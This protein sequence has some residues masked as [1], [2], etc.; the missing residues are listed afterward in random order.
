MPTD[1]DNP[2][3]AAADLPNFA[4]I[5]AEHVA[6]AVAQAVATARSQLA[7]IEGLSLEQ[8]PD[9]LQGLEKIADAVGRVW[10]P[11]EHLLSVRDDA[12]MRQA[13]EVAQP[14]IVEV[15]IDIAQNQLIYQTLVALVAS[16]LWANVP[17]FARRA[18][19]LTVREAQ[20]AGVGLQ[21]QAA[22][23]FGE[24]QQQLAELS[25]QFAH[26]VLDS[27]K[28]WHLDLSE[29]TD[30][31]GLP[32]TWLR[33][34]AQSW[35]QA[36]SQPPEQAPDFTQGPWRVTL[37]A[38][39]VVGL[40]QHSPRRQLRQTVWR[41]WVQRASQ[42][43]VDNSPIIKQMLRLRTE[44]AHLLGQPHYA[45][46]SLRSKMAPSVAIVDGLLERLRVASWTAAQGDLQDLRDLARQS[47]EQQASDLRPWDVAFWTERLREKRYNFNDESVR[48]FFPM[49]QVLRGLF[50]LAKSLFGIEI[51]AA[52]GQAPVWHPDVR[53]FR[54]RDAAGQLV[55]A[56]YLDP[57][58]RPQDKR[59]GAWM[60]ECVGRGSLPAADGT[61]RIAV[62]YLVCNAAPPADGRPALMT[63]SEVETLLH[64]FGHGLQHMLTKVD[65]GLVSGIRGVDWDAVE[66]PSQFMENWCYHQPTLRGL[67]CHVETAQ[68]IDD[69]LFERIAAARVFRAGSDMLR[70][71]L[72]AKLDLELHGGFD[73][74]GPICVFDVY[75]TIAVATNPLPIEADDHFLCG[76][77]HI[78]GGGYAAGYYSYKWAEVL[79]AD[80]FAAFEEAGLSD[81]TAVAA[82]G[83]RFADTVLA[84]G[85]AVDPASVFRQF[86]GR[87]PDEHAL[88]RHAGLAA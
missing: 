50:A 39:C 28:A 29:I 85:G 70:Q 17:P 1:A 25:T 13:H 5:S 11:I 78:F 27:T 79:S 21:G 43:P 55:A 81:P 51:D 57:F 9:I 10:G 37:E 24:I 64:E 65:L 73:P 46:L 76:F 74:D 69:A 68:P 58:S 40:L 26:H 31:E 7:Q 77:S 41:A 33:M 60:N 72:F 23:R 82:V 4:A 75:R 62:A 45:A 63:F 12:Q 44:M 14:A 35:R 47:D 6:P 80:A 49:P 8:W 56:F 30:I 66:L 61:A 83:A 20:L 42:G 38:P 15:S 52:D 2:L 59:G 71:L 84:L 18:I 36:Q 3:L 54:V 67:S 48:K 34:T 22:A 19:E 87:D 53:F 32:E 88:L 16:P 86:R